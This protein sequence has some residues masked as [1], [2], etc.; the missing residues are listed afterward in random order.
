MLSSRWRIKSQGLRRCAGR[1]AAAGAALGVAAIV[2]GATLFG[3]GQPTANAAP[4]T[5]QRYVLT[6]VSSLTIGEGKSQ[7]VKVSLS[8]QPPVDATVV[9]DTTSTTDGKV[10]FDKSTLTFTTSNW[11][12]QQ[13][14]TVTANDDSVDQ[15]KDLTGTILIYE[16]LQIYAPKEL[17]VTIEDDD[18]PNIVVSGGKSL[19]IGEGNSQAVKVSLDRKPL[20]DV[21]VSV[22]AAKALKD[23]VT[24]TASSLTFTTSNWSTKQ[25]VTITTVDDSVDQAADLTGNVTFSRTYQG[26]S[27]SEVLQV[28]IEDDDNPNIVVSGQK[29][30]TIDEGSSQDVS[31][32][33]S[34]QPAADVTVSVA[35]ADA[36]KNA[37]T[38]TASSL[39][40]TTSNWS[41]NQTVTITAVDDSVDQPTDL[42][43]NV[44]F[45]RTYQGRAA[46][47]AVQ[48]T[49]DD[50]DNPY[51]VIS[52]QKSLTIAE[53]TNQTVGVSLSQ[54]PPWDTTDVF[55]TVEDSLSYN[56]TKMVTVNPG[57]LYFTKSNWSQAQTVTITAVNDSVD[58]PADLSGSVAFSGGAGR[59]EFRTVQVTIEDDED[60]AIVIS[61][62]KSLTIDEGSSQ[63]VSVS[64][65]RQ[66]PA[67]VTV[68]VA[69]AESLKDAVTLNASSLTFTTSNWSTKQ[70]VTISAVDDS[71]YQATDPTGNVTFSRTYQGR[72][73]NQAV[74]VTVDDNDNPYIVV[75]GQTPLTIGEGQSQDVKVSLN[76]RLS[77]DNDVKVVVDTTSTTNGKVTFDKSELTFTTSNWSKP[78]TV[79]VTAVDDSVDQATDVTG[80]ILIY[81]WLQIYASQEVGVTIEDDDNP[82]IVVSGQKSLTIGEGNSQNVQVS[83]DRKPLADVTVSVAASESLKDA[84]TLS[85]SSLTFTTSNWSTQQTVTITAVDDSVDQT[86]NLAGSVTFSRTYQGRAASQVIQV[87]VADNDDPV[88]TLTT[89]V[90]TDRT[91]DLSLAHGP[92]NWWFRINSGGCTAVSGTAVNNISGYQSGTHNV[93]AYSD[94]GCSAQIATASFVIPPPVLTATVDDTDNTVDLSLDHG[95]SNWWFNINTGGGCTA[96]SGTAVNNISGYQSGTHDVAAYSNSGCSAQIATASFTIQPAALT[97]MVDPDKSVDL[98]LASGPSNWWFKFNNSGSCMAA[99]GTRVNDVQGWQSGSNNVAAYSDS[100]CSSQIAT[101]PFTIAPATLTATVD[102]D[103]TVDLSLSNGPSSWWFRINSGGCTAASG[104]AYNG[105]SGYAPGTYTVTAYSDSGCNGQIGTTSFTMPPPVLTATVDDTDNTVDLALAGGPSNWWFNINSGGGCTAVSGTAVNNISGYGPATYTVTAYSDSGCNGQIATTSFTIRQATLTTTV[106]S[107]RSVDLSLANGTSNWWFRVGSSGCTAVSGTAHNGITGYLTGTHT[108]KAYSNSGCNSQIATATFTIPPAVLTTTLDYSDN[109]V[110]LSLAHGPS[111]WW[112]NINSSGCTAASGTTHN[113]ITG[114]APGTHTVTVYSDSGCGSQIA[115]TSFTIQP[116]VL[117]ATVDDTDHSV[118]LSLANGPANWWFKF[119]N[120]GACTA[121]SGTAVNNAQGWQSGSNNVAAY[122]NSGCSSQ[123]ATASFTISSAT[124]TA[125]VDDTDNSVDLSLANGPSNWWFKINSDSCT[126]VSGTAHNGVSGYRSGTHSV[127]AYSDSGC[128]GQIATASFTITPPNIVVSGQTSLTIAE[129]ESKD[130]GVKLSKQPQA[131]ATVSIAVSATLT[132]VVTVSKSSLTFTTSNWSQQQTVTINAVEDSIYQATDLT[133]SVTFSHTD[134][135]LTVSQAVQV[136]A[137]DNDS[138]MVMV[139]GSASLTIRE[140]KSQNVG[141]SLNSQITAD[142]TVSITVA[143]ALKDAVTLSKS[144]LTFTS[145]NWSQQQTVTISAVDDTIDQATNP[146]GNVTFSHDNQTF[147]SKTVQVTVADDDDPPITLTPTVNYTTVDLVMAHGPSQWWFRVGSDGACTEALGTSATIGILGYATGTYSI[148]AYAKTGCHATIATTSFTILPTTLTATVNGDQSVDL[149]L[150]NGPPNWRFKI[151]S[152]GCNSA[153]GTSVNGISGYAAGTHNVV[154]YSDSGCNTQIASTSF[155]IL[156]TTLTATVDNDQA[157]NDKSVDLALANGPANW[158][159]KIGSGSCTAASGTDHNDITGHSAGTHTVTAY[160]DSGC[161]AQIAST[162]F[163]ILAT[164]LTAAADNNQAPN[165]KSVDLALANGPANWWFKIGSGSCTAASGTA[166]NDITGHSAGTHTVTAHSDSGCSAHMAATSFTILATTLTATVDNDQAPNAKSVDLALANGPSNW[167]FR[168]N[169]GTCTSVS[170]TSV[171]GIS[172]YQ[173]AA[174]FVYAYSDSG[175]SAEIATASFL[176]LATTLT[177]TVNGDQS[178]DLALANGPANWWFK[179]NSGS[180]VAASGTAHNGHTGHGSGTHTVTA[181]SDSGCSAQMVATSFTVLVTTLTATVDNNQADG[182]KSVDLALANGPSNWWFRINSGTCTAVSGTSVNGI[183]G[184]GPATY[185]VTAYSDSGCSAQLATTSFTILPTQFSVSVSS[186]PLVNLSMVNG[187]H[188]WWFKINSGTCT[189]ASGTSYN[190]IGGYGSGTHTVTVYSA[191]GCS[192]PMGSTSFI[193]G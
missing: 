66:P 92:S 43:G 182:N 29:S 129:G 192:S 185:T 142:E 87:T 166:H 161:S 175:C 56:N 76:A 81:E 190:G 74:Q 61:G 37:V 71:V 85:A 188:N 63:D 150:A 91:V 187:P 106:N 102:S 46:S 83:L 180:C 133:G 151:N 88:T 100:G 99:S 34:R 191:S 110:D 186:G 69:A 123:I 145:S 75:S 27:A 64:L 49:V 157:P 93:V 171:N 45:S 181:Y 170:G 139:S 122:S 138:A 154:A 35:V 70:T 115:T 164:T 158:W 60:P 52:G 135:G 124:L 165:D 53:G 89:T 167:W 31:V 103:R 73:T 107:D 112:F 82:N 147:A 101:T 16:W 109:S 128:N 3:A 149:A 152:G 176:I 44:T 80:T 97:V 8:H 7:D 30:L 20:E 21:T 168:I 96:V 125:T 77:N 50:N 137:D 55:I 144:S 68:S 22:A 98:S 177:A 108:V 6:D 160:S 131:N 173:P 1:I 148:T 18:N 132:D 33:L 114:Y 36:L 178:V 179:V 84:V 11:S 59:Y 15:T 38:L 41:T 163:T 90:D 72:T 25:T 105:I 193:I 117:T 172:G 79:T 104:T 136:T 54:Q 127:K 146:T 159:F 183:S 189:A 169:S 118:N 14:V 13:T 153:S 130:V 95:P 9:V 62:Q 126:A 119:N 39:T 67:N 156:A 42:T 28:T 184:Y 141:V 32:A 12:T 134:Q 58:Q 51:V 155:T 40:F 48:V 174:H 94:S 121:A 111:N 26:R 2:A 57:V 143:D 140:G 78:Q 10:T 4:N 162:S 86:T 23:A 113:G 17:E 24:L 47:Q 116:A 5:A 65:N 19:T 120:S